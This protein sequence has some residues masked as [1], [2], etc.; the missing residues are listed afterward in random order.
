MKPKKRIK[1]KY[2]DEAQPKNDYNFVEVLVG[3]LDALDQYINNSPQVQQV[4]GST[5]QSNLSTSD[6]ILDQARNQKRQARLL[7]K[8]LQAASKTLTDRQFEIFTL[9]FIMGL[10]EEEIASRVT[11]QFVGRPRLT[12]VTQKA[13]KTA[14]QHVSQPYVTGVLER[15]IVKIKKVLRLK[16]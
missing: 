2:F 14:R 4:L 11:R 3:D 9:R 1:D 13:P 5:F 10:T 12:G 6:K 7:R 8:V 15:S 16:S